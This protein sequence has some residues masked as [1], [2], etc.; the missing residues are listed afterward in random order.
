MKKF[1]LLS[2]LFLSL[3]LWSASK[4]RVY[5]QDGYLHCG[6]TEV[7]NEIFRANPHIKEE[8]LKQEAKATLE[9]LQ[10]F[11]KGYKE[12]D[13]KALPPIYII[14]IVF[15]IIHIGGAENIS[16]AQIHD[17]V[18]VLNEDFRKLNSTSANTVS[19]FQSIAADCEIE[20]R[21]AQKDPNGNCTN[22]I[23]RIV[24]TLTNAADD[25]SKLNGWPRDKYLNVW[26]VKTIASGA[27][28]YAYLPST[29]AF[30][31]STD[32]I[33]ILSGY[34]GSIGTGSTTTSHALTHEIGHFLNLKHTW[35]DTNNPGVDCSGSDNVND[36]PPTEGWLTCNLSGATCGSALD[37]VQN[38]MEYSYCPT[39]YTAGQ[40]TRMRTALTSSTASRNNLWTTNNLS[41]T[42]VSLP[43]VLCTADFKSSSFTNT[44]CQGDSLTFTNLSW[45]GTPTSWSWTFQGGTPATST[46]SLPVVHYNT[47]GVYDVSLTVSNGSGSATANKTAF[48]TINPSTAIYNASFYSEGFEG[49][50]IPNTD[51]KIHNQTPGGNTWVQTSTAA[52]S[53][54]KSVMITNLTNSD[55]FVDELI[56]PSIDMT[57]I[58]G[59]INIAFK[60]AYAQRSTTTNDKLQ[61]YVSTNCGLSWNLRKTMTGAA[62]STGGVQTA[63]FTPTASQWAQQVVSLTGYTLQTNLFIMFRFTSNGGNNIYLDDINIGGTAGMVDNLENFTNF[64]IYPNPTEENTM[65]SFNTIEKQ[66]V[67]V[68]IYDLVGAEVSSVFSGD[69]NTGE[70]QY[71]IEKK[72][73]LAPGVYFVTLSIDKQHFTKKLIIK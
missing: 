20:F 34:V 43:A 33:L 21:L 56:S 13:Q 10:A 22:G 14:P 27:A 69:L 45:N 42:G 65:I 36:T 48:I 26:V 24:S 37:N 73:N 3:I 29:A 35:G 63:S 9:D 39:M 6:T 52:A 16:D 41:F 25:N 70:H 50:G 2:I 71:S 51:W 17:E 18:R 30:M 28:G 68:K 19:A 7:Q 55:T 61:V 23:D 66:K 8:Y 53:G 44:V 67:E 38:Y 31:P 57:A 15:H 64:N 32:G 12:N 1:C 49:S 72:N 11:S 47:S 46:D 40:K 62:L 59:S 5:A 4:N 58:T 60:V 54:S